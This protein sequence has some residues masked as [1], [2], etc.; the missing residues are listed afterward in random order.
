MPGPFYIQGQAAAEQAVSEIKK[1]LEVVEEFRNAGMSPDELAG[2][3]KQWIEEFHK[4]L[5]STETLCN[6][7]LDAE[8]YRLGNN[9]A[10]NFAEVVK[11]NNPDKMKEA[12]KEWIF[13]GGVLIY[14]RGPAVNLRSDLES[15]GPVRPA[16]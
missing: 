15:L 1:V 14:V 4:T 9:Y 5:E 2:V 12:V 10:S 8:L 11:R 13:P 16:S 7:L 3:Q 6:V